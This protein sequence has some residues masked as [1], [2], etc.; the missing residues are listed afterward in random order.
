MLTSH[1]AS[2]LTS[3]AA[4]ILFE[5]LDWQFQPSFTGLLLLNL[6]P[7]ITGH[8]SLWQ[9]PCSRMV[10][11]SPGNSSNSRCCQT[12]SQCCLSPRLRHVQTAKPLLGLFDVVFTR[13]QPREPCSSFAPGVPVVWHVKGLRGIA[14]AVQLQL[15]VIPRQISLY[16]RWQPGDPC[17]SPAH[18]LLSCCERCCLFCVPKRIITIIGNIREVFSRAYTS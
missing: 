14:S 4:A 11:A 10:A 13:V 2:M 5:A 9:G 1:A 15:F 17:L 18:V 12:S 7:S 3:H 8:Y 16:F 6:S